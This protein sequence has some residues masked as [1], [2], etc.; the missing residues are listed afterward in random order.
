MEDEHL[1]TFE[2]RN[3]APMVSQIPPMTEETLGLTVREE[4]EV[5]DEPEEV[6]GA[7]EIN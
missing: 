7:D 5:E 1:G 2:T 4:M 3:Q 6:E